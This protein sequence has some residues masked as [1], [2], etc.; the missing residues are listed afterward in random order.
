MIM[1]FTNPW[2]TQ[3]LSVGGLA[4]SP[5]HRHVTAS[6]NTKIRL[7]PTMAPSISRPLPVTARPNLFLLRACGH[8]VFFLYPNFTVSPHPASHL[9]STHLCPPTSPSKAINCCNLGTQSQRSPRAHELPASPQPSAMQNCTGPVANAAAH[10]CSRDS[11]HHM[12][13]QS[14]D[15]LGPTTTCSHPHRHS[16]RLTSSLHW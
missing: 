16:P 3:D 8:S 5:I 2:G 4:L 11:S 9:E 7:P 1:P 10:A 12:P 6:K 14:G 13:S 15:Q